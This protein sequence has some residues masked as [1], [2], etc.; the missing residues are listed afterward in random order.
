M[1][2]VFIS[3]NIDVPELENALDSLTIVAKSEVEEV[4]EPIKQVPESVLMDFS[5]TFKAGTRGFKK[6]A[7]KK[8]VPT[9]AEIEIA[10]NIE[11]NK[12]LEDANFA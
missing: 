2:T 12:D 10:S 4:K 8:V 1:S 11:V 5:N 7:P 9:N 3:E 6:K